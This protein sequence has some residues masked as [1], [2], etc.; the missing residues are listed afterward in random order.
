VSDHSQLL[1]D[2]EATAEEAEPLA[3]ALLAWLV[4]EGIVEESASDCVL[5]EG[6]GHRP[7]PR[8]R[9]ALA[10]H[11]ADDPF[12]RLRTNGLALRTGRQVF[13]AGENGVELTCPSCQA[14]FEPGEDWA[15]AVGAWYDGDD[16]TTFACPSCAKAQR[17]GDWRGPRPWGFGHLALEVWNWPPLSETF[18]R[19]VAE[20]A[21]HRIVV[22][23]RNL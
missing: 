6:A 12:L 21:K 2:L 8:C 14:T 13:D 19:A 1:V 20:R 23:R 22:V 18:V 17:L 3:R 16:G 10:P 15:K 4:A 7:G 9:H 11:S 5:G